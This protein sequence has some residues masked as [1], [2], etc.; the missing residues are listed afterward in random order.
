MMMTM[1]NDCVA[2]SPQATE[3]GERY[4]YTFS[5]ARLAAHRQA[6]QALRSGARPE[7]AATPTGSWVGTESRSGG[8]TSS[9]STSST[10]TRSNNSNGVGGKHGDSRAGAYLSRDGDPDINDMD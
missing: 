2:P 9:T 1:S 6:L 7:D 10:S 8:S 4:R 5:N 3:V